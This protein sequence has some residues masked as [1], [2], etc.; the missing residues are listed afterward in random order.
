MVPVPG[1]L[2]SGIIL[3]RVFRLNMSVVLIA[4]FM[5]DLFDKPLR[6]VFHI[7]PFGRS[8]LHS[9]SGLCLVSLIVFV[10]WGKKAGLSWV[11]G[12]GGHI[13]CDIIGDITALHKINIPWFWPFITYTFPHAS[14]FKVSYCALSV[15][16][17]LSIIA[18]FMI[19]PELK[20]VLAYLRILQMKNK[21]E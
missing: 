21:K 2:A 13:F 19:K 20:K 18:F 1:H 7:F 11:V 4:T 12:H 14:G 17:I 15:E 10:F 5:P 9:I 16:I 6:Y 3:S 8:I